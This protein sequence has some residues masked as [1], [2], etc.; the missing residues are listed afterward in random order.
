MDGI[1]PLLRNKRRVILLMGGNYEEV[2]KEIENKIVSYMTTMPRVIV[3]SVSSVGESPMN[4]EASTPILVDKEVEETVKPDSP[5]HVVIGSES[6]QV[7]STKI[8]VNEEEE[9]PFKDLGPIIFGI[10]LNIPTVL[11]KKEKRM[12]RRR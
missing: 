11:M 8:I 9:D 4:I 5:P 7:D 12:S 1:A 10:L 2:N 3:E 6:I